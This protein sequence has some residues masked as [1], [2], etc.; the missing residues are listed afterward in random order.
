MSPPDTKTRILKTAQKLFAQKGIGATSL[1][2]ITRQ[3]GV[4]LA[5]V[6]YHFGSKEGLIRALVSRLFGPIN[7]ERLRLLDGIEAR[8]GDGPP[9]L[10]AVVEAFVGPPIHLSQRP[11][12]RS[13]MALVGRLFGDPSDR[14]FRIFKEEMSEIAHRFGRALQHALPHLPPG[15]VFSRLAFSAGAMAHTMLLREDL[16]REFTDGRMTLGGPDL[17][18]RRLVAFLSGGLRAPAPEGVPA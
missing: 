10:E 4:N 17:I 13:A 5:A 1:R 12:G 14:T 11:E 6:H 18:V 7:Q 2:E 3:A 16:V 8:A 15:E 9:D